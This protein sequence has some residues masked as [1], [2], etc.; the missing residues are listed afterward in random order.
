MVDKLVSFKTIAHVQACIQLAARSLALDDRLWR[1]LEN[2]L[3]RAT[4]T[5]AALTAYRFNA[6]EAQQWGI[7]QDIASEAEVLTKAVAL[8][9]KYASLNRKTLVTHKQL[10]HGDA[11][12]FLGYSYR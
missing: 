2:R 12:E 1:I 11:A 4:A 3:P 7:V 5:T 8:A 9:E 6:V 10:A